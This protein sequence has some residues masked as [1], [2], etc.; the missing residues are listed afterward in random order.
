MPVVTSFYRF[1]ACQS[2][3]KSVPEA[4]TEIDTFIR[5]DLDI[6]QTS[7]PEPVPACDPVASV[8]TGGEAVSSEADSSKAD[9][10]KADNSRLI[11]VRLM[12]RGC[13]PWDNRQRCLGLRGCGI[14]SAPI[15]PASPAG[16][17]RRRQPHSHTISHYV[18]LPVYAWGAADWDLEVIQPLLQE[19]HPT[20]GFSLTEA[21][22]AARVTVVGGNGAISAEALDM[23]RASGCKVERVMDDGTLIAS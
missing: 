17:K 23:L 13:Q 15:G 9:S 12:Q 8:D 22:L 2:E 11:T 18:L 4:A 7:M 6:N 21:R 14:R 16:S 19:S 3:T 5:D 1:S 20:V 10:N